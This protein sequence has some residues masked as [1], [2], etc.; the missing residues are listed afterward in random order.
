MRPLHLLLLT[1]LLSASLASPSLAQNKG[2]KITWKRTVVDKAFRSEGVAV[3]DVNKDGK[4]DII[5][6]DVWYE[7]PTWKMHPL[8]TPRDPKKSYA[9]DPQGYSECFQV[10]ADDFNGDGYPD[11]I[12]IP[13]P[14]KECFWYENPGKAGGLWKEHLLTT[15]ACNE[16]PIFVDLFK[17]GKKVLVMAWQPAGK[18]NMGEM[19]YF[20]PGKE[21][22]KPWTRFSVSGPS[23]TGKEI[24]FTQRYSHGLGHGDVNGDGRI[25]IL[26][27]GGW[28]EQPVKTT[29]APWVFH[30][31]D[32]GPLCADMHVTDVDSDGKADVI[33]SAAHLTGMWWHR[34]IEGKEPAFARKE[35]FP[36]PR[37]L[38]VGPKDEP[39]SKEENAVYSAVNKI[40]TEGKKFPWRSSSVLT[41]QARAS[42]AG[43]A[44]AVKY[45][46]KV[47]L[48][49]EGKVDANPADTIKKVLK[50]HPEIRDP[51]IEVGVGVHEGKF[52]VVLGDRRLYSQPGQTHALHMLDLNGDGVLDLVTGR[53]FWAHGPNGDDAPQDP[54][55]VYWYQGKRDSK[56]FL[57][58]TPRRVDDDSGIGTQ[59]DIHDI[60]GDGAPDII[61]SNKFGV[62]VFE[63][64]RTKE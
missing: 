46:G 27:P 12:V 13:H 43:D 10:F 49:I 18:S 60:N 56:G 64:I 40:R 24:P 50:D 21:V 16:T 34:Q 19:C 52:V 1:C 4:P 37:S 61:V 54:P 2:T 8:R 55:V 6:G 57:T 32:L 33:T 17:T 41:K 35:L 7:A 23:E 45:A 62:Y 30:K 42:L 15:S 39:F 63:Q 14:G 44:K 20:I 31:A 26:C 5:T 22:T 11:A 51:G 58:F 29:E 53:R 47:L 28:W 38:A 59:F 36:D 25:D 3:A 48:S 9:W